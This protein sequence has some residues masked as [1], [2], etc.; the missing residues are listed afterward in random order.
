MIFR[1]HIICL[2]FIIFIKSVSYAAESP[3]LNPNPI[4]AQVSTE[5]IEYVEVLADRGF[6]Q[7]TQEIRTES[8]HITSGSNP[9]HIERS[10]QAARTGSYGYTI[11]AGSGEGVNLR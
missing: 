2:I 4:R 3:C 6:E 10:T 11:T 7:G 8:P 9:I 5:I 1:I